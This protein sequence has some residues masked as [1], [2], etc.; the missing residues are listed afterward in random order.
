MDPDT[1]EEKTIETDQAI[2][3][4]RSDGILHITFKEE[5]EIDVALQDQMIL[6][7]RELCGDKKRPFLY[8]G[9][10]DVSITKEGREYSRQLEDVFPASAAA[11]I[12][13]NIAYKLIANFYLKVNKP[14]T[15]Y[16]VFNDISSAE[17]WLKT[18]IS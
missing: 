4:L 13:D 17:E 6:I 12:A 14:K 18:F 8:S 9:I 15:P 11:V 2:V 16:K 5:T 7:Y 1:F 10:G 3:H